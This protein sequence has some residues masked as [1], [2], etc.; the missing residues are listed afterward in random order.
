[1]IKKVYVK[2]FGC[3]M[4][5]YDL[6]KMVDVFNVV[7]G[8]EKIDMLEDV[9]IIL[10]NMCLVCEKVQEKVFFDFGCVC[11]LKEVKFGLL[12]GVGGCVVSQEGVLIVLCVLYVDFVFGLQILYCLLQMIDVCCVSGCVQVDI[13]F[14]E[15]E[16]FDYLL[17]VCVEGLSV[18]VLIMEGCLKYCSYCVVLYMCGDEV[19]CL[20]DDVLIEVVGFV[21]QGVCEVMLFGQ[22]V[23]VY[24]GVLVVGLFEIV[25]FV[26]LI[27]YVVDIFGIEWICYMMLY[28][29]EFMQC[30]IDIYVKV[31]KF[32]N[33][34]YLLVQYGFDCILMVMKCGYM[35]FEYKL[36]I[37]KLCVI[38]FDLLLLIDMIVGFFGEIEDDFDKMMVF[39]YE[40]GYDISF[41]FIYSLC[42]GMLVVNFV[43]DML[44][45]VKFKCL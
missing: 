30:L 2:I 40:M 18:F 34:L 5:E 39:V 26:M 21:D 42:F 41:L 7:E 12:I 43:D 32:V 16:K 20:F 6:D 19:L 22:N 35:V 17:F 31:L 4:N 37:C 36:V 24:C 11:E 1:M 15:I 25:D 33:Y 10:F 28:L 3:Q 44:C 8:F 9:D 13:M 27:E 14:F 45:D 23:N 38:C 29:K